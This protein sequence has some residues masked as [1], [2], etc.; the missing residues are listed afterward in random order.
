MPAIKSVPSL[1]AAQ[2]T[3][4]VY[5][6]I[7]LNGHAE[8]KH[9]SRITLHSQAFAREY[10]AFYRKGK[11]ITRDKKRV[12]RRSNIGNGDDDETVF[13]NRNVDGINSDV[14]GLYG[15][16][17]TGL[18]SLSPISA[19]KKEREI[20]LL[21]VRAGYLY[22]SSGKK[23]IA[24]MEIMA[25]LTVGGAMK[26]SYFDTRAR[27]VLSVR[28]IPARFAV[29]E[30]VS[31]CLASHAMASNRDSVHSPLISSASF[32]KEEG[33]KWPRVEE[34]HGIAPVPRRL[35]SR[36]FL[37]SSSMSESSLKCTKRAGIC[38]FSC[39]RIPCDASA[40]NYCYEQETGMNI[41][42]LLR[43]LTSADT[44]RRA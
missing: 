27:T 41:E 18:P 3:K 25:W 15:P 33:E 32:E 39:I 28:C 1:R 16:W 44:G 29:R 22:I 6:N 14:C 8:R 24:I 19:R 9:G 40:K 36:R 13:L 21:S 30:S 43:L 11:T 31:R 20:C 23:K 2:A 17:L 7:H 26:L 10:A 5:Y 38:A 42:T 12:P 34:R 35:V 37:P 4:P